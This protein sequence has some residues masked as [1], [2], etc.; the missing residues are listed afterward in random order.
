VPRT[1]VGRRVSGHRAGRWRARAERARRRPASGP[2]PPVAGCASASSA[3]TAR[4][5]P[6]AGQG[7]AGGGSPP[8]PAGAA[9]SRRVS[10]GPG[11]SRPAR[12][13][14]RPGRRGRRRCCVAA[15]PAARRARRT[16]AAEWARGEEGGQLQQ[17]H[18]GR[19]LARA[20]APAT[21]PRRCR[22]PGVADH[23]AA[24]Q[25]GRPVGA[26]AAQIVR[27]RQVG[28]LQVA[29]GLRGGQRQIAQLGGE[30]VGQLLVQGRDAGTQQRDR[31][32]PGSARRL[33]AGHLARPS[34]GKREV[35]S[36]CPPPPG[37]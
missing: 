31:L 15:P 25:Q 19:V 2:D 20:A 16:G 5:W 1:V 24:G 30:L 28:L 12:R 17:L 18:R 36:A 10:G 35:I 37:R 23:V 7:S 27:R 33:P 11:S 21:A 14:C 6:A 3:T 32:R 34:L 29:G 13:R 4:R 26:E 22:P 8:A 9:G